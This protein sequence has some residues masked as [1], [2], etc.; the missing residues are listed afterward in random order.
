MRK[1]TL[2]AAGTAVISALLLGGGVSLALS[3]G[4]AVATG[5]PAAVTLSAETVQATM[6]LTEVQLVRLSPPDPEAARFGFDVS[7]P[8]DGV[9]ATLSLEPVSVRAAG[10]RVLAQVDDQGTLVEVPAG[11]ENTYQGTIA[12]I[13]AARVAASVDEEG[14][15]AHIVMPD[16]TMRVIEPLAGRVPG[17]PPS[18]FVVYAADAAPSAGGICGTDHDHLLGEGDAGEPSIETGAGCGA[19]C[20]AEIAFDADFEYYQSRG[21]SVTNVENRLNAVMNVANLQVYETDVAIRHVIT[22]IIVRSNVNDPYTSADSTTLL[23]QF[24]NH[25]LTSQQSIIRDVAC[26]AT[27]RDITGTVIGQA[28]T[29]GGICTTS[30]YCFTQLE[31]C[32]SHPINCAADLLAHEL[33]H[34][35]GASHVSDGQTMNPSITCALNFNQTNRNQIIAHRNSRNCLSAA[36]PPGDF[37]LVTPANGATGVPIDTIFDWTD[38]SDAATYTLV[39][40]DDPNFGTPHVISPSSEYASVTESQFQ[41][42]LPLIPGRTYYWRVTAVNN[43]GETLTTPEVASFTTIRDCNMNGID[44]AVEVANPANDC[45]GNGIPDSCDLAG[46]V[47]LDSEDIPNLNFGLNVDHEFASAPEAQAGVLL[48]VRAIGDLSTLSEFIDVEINGT[49]VGQ[50]FDGGFSDCRLIEDFIPIPKDTFNAARGAGPGVTVTL[51]PSAGVSSSCLTGHYTTVRL[52]YLGVPGSA[53]GNSN[54]VP[55]ECEGPQFAAGDMNC[56]G[57]ISVSDIGP[58]VLAITDPAGYIAAFPDCDVNLADVNGDN[59]LSVSDIGP[60]VALLTQP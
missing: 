12:A 56:D 11:P 4:D 35:W 50:V 28:W 52:E 40:D 20:V 58:F 30:A 46:F 14:F 49:P 38:S 17:A 39:I 24:R 32:N 3:G 21:S 59:N 36:A 31:C 25:W 23:T 43:I 16:R 45:N 7:V 22:T 42:L 29:I 41:S 27:G 48:T 60:F 10:Y 47:R 15:I 6:G 57:V 55:D 2:L 37:T 54:N 44:D 5:G 9:M 34:L 18:D 51:V 26:L 33:G 53:D 13:P 19:M 8:I 1:S